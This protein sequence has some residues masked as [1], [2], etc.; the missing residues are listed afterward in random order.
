MEKL[1]DF[2]SMCKTVNDI[3]ISDGDHT[4][5]S[6]LMQELLV[7]IDSVEST[8]R[9]GKVFARYIEETSDYSIQ[10]K[11]DSGGHVNILPYKM[12]KKTKIFHRNVTIKIDFIQWLH[13]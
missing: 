8:K 11:I 6:A 9:N 5:N 3:Q 4:Y 2:S 7:F 10:F 13:A 12:Y 1:N